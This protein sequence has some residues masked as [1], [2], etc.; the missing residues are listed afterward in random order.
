MIIS[1]SRRTDIPAFYSAWFMNRI[2]AGHCQVP[3]PFNPRQVMT[4]SLEPEDVDVLV[5]W[6]RNA[7]PLL[8]HLDELDRKGY[9]YLFLYTVMNNPRPIDPR[10]PSLEQAL[11]AFKALSD[12]IGPE[13]VIW[14]YDPVVFSNA[15]NAEF[16]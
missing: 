3:N 5:F 4:V 10:C 12:R 6:T 9:R 16:H 15:S 13:R 8:N 7:T 2:D 1:A 14:R 11:A